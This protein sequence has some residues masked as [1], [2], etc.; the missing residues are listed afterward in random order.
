MNGI[1]T[2]RPPIHVKISHEAVKVQN[3]NWLIGQNSL[4]NLFPLRVRGKINSINRD[5]A[6]AITPPSLFGIDR[7]MAYTHKKY[8][9][10]LI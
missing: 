8:H 5:I 2:G 7:K 6:S 3:K 4:P 10:G 1:S 9:S